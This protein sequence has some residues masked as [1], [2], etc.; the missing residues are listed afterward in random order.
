MSRLWPSGFPPSTA[1]STD[2]HD[3][4]GDSDGGGEEKET[5]TGR[6][7]VAEPASLLPWLPHA[8]HEAKYSEET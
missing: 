5:T 2:N 6:G 4:G 3:G 1:A 8:G 7:R